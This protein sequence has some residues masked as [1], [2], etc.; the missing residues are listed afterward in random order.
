MK[1]M[2]YLL[3]FAASL[4][5]ANPLL[6]QSLNSTIPTLKIK[7]TDSKGV[8]QA[9]SVQDAVQLVR[10]FMSQEGIERC[11]SDI[12]NRKLKLVA[13]PD[14]DLYAMLQKS[15]VREKIVGMGF[16]FDL[17]SAIVA[18][19]PIDA[20][21]TTVKNTSTGIANSTTNKSGATDKKSLLEKAKAI[22]AAKANAASSAT[23]TTSPTHAAKPD[24]A[25]CGEVKL[26]QNLK[27][28]ITKNADYSN[29]ELMIDMPMGNFDETPNNSEKRINTAPASAP[30]IAPPMSSSQLDSLRQILFKKRPK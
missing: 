19:T 25:D 1:S 10:F 20:T 28:S 8:E 6:A 21:A 24:C 5:G 16:A 12:Y 30:T 3:L 22:S 18:T 27:E 9:F 7:K 23:K 26:D 11:E 2:F 14:V 13:R 15:N 4:L 29:S 17:P